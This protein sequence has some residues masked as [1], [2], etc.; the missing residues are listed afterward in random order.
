MPTVSRWSDGLLLSMRKCSLCSI[1]VHNGLFFCSSLLLEL[2]INT[3]TGGIEMVTIRMLN[4]LPR[5]PA[6]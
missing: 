2:S 4:P 6:H 5:V 1:I 3:S